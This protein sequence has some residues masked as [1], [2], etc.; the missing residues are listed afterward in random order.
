MFE[1]ILQNHK[2]IKA[3]DIL[4][5]MSKPG[6]LVKPPTVYRAIDFLLEHGFIHKIESLNAFIACY[7]EHRK[8]C[9]Q[10]LICDEC[11]MVEEQ[12]NSKICH[13]INLSSEQ[14]GFILKHPVVEL[15]GICFQCNKADA[16]V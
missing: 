3:Y 5:I 8:E 13:E 9:F 7:H 15:H 4:K 11:G 14:A 2:A 6:E 10:L 16:L 1:E 12:T